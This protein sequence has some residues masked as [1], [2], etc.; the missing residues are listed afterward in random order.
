MKKKER[1]K[2]EQDV[3]LQNHTKMMPVIDIDIYKEILRSTILRDKVTEV[4]NDGITV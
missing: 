4:W 3:F 2:K 1:T